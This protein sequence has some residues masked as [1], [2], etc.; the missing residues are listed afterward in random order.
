MLASFSIPPFSFWYCLFL[1]WRRRKKKK[2]WTELTNRS[3]TSREMWCTVVM[4]PDT[5]SLVLRLYI[6]VLWYPCFILG[7]QRSSTSTSLK[8]LF[9]PF[10]R[11]V[12]NC[13]WHFTAC[14]CALVRKRDWSSFVLSLRR[15]S[16][17]WIHYSAQHAGPA[18]K[19]NPAF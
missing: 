13:R 8:A 14:P 10:C 15:C 9:F 1:W 17:S 12:C 16:R 7:K 5:A 4:P 11:H 19:A 3:I 18:A 2:I 6:S